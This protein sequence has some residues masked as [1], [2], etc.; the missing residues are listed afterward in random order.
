ML[1]LPGLWLD[2]RL[3]LLVDCVVCPTTAVVFG[4]GSDEFCRTH[5]T[6]S[7][8]HHKGIAPVFLLLAVV[9]L[10]QDWYRNKV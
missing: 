3:H 4:D 8:L 1:A 6:G 9:Q 5:Q 7:S 2:R 10:S